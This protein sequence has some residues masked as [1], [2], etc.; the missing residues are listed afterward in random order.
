MVALIELK[1]IWCKARLVMPS[2][3]STKLGIGG[4]CGQEG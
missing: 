3:K 4:R 1:A 2:T